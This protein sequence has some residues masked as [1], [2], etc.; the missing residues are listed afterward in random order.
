MA[1]LTVTEAESAVLPLLSDA[2]AA[3]TAGGLAMSV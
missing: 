3:A 1:K 2:R